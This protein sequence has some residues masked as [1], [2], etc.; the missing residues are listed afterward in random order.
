VFVR[1]SRHPSV[2]ALTVPPNIA[3]RTGVYSGITLSVVFIA[4]IFVAY[5]IPFLHAFALERNLTAAIL[6]CL[7]AMI[8]VLRFLLEP[9]K[10]WISS[11]I[12][13]AIFSVTYAL[14]SAYF[15]GLR[16]HFGAF[17]VFMLGA[18]PYMIVATISWLGSIVWRARVARAAHPRR[19]AS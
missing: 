6:L 10:L 5:R 7:I 16:E 2:T 3:V 13:W 8:P 4:W 9:A 14:L 15:G 18:V 1:F 17:Q 11:L 19:S 12:A